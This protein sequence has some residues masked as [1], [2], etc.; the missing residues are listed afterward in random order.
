MPHF[1]KISRSPIIP[2]IFTI[3]R[4]KFLEYKDCAFIHIKKSISVGIDLVNDHWKTI[5]KNH[6]NL[7][8][9]K[10]NNKIDN[11]QQLIDY[12][13]I[14][15]TTESPFKFKNKLGFKKR[16]TAF[17]PL[18]QNELKEY[19][20]GESTKGLLLTRVDSFL[21]LFFGAKK[22]DK[23]FPFYLQIINQTHS[24]F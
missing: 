4:K 15:K 22:N 14:N 2:G 1:K 7:F 18:S 20:L 24:F 9:P 16:L 6:Q 23:K 19:Y 5:F 8:P 11:N 3:P 12:I 21:N 17:N 10:D 13:L